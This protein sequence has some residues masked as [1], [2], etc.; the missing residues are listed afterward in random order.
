[1]VLA[2]RGDRQAF[3]RLFDRHQSSIVRFCA[4]FVGNQ[5]RGEELAQDVFIKLFR[6]AGRYRPEAKFTTFLFRVATNTCLNELRHQTHVADKADA[7]GDETRPEGRPEAAS[8]ESPD[9]HLEAKDVEKA[10]GLAL[11]GMSPRERAAFSMCRFEGLAYKDIGDALEASEAAVKSLIHRATLQVMERL[12][13]VRRGED[14][15]Q[16][17]HA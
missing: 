7:E 1:M 8:A 10:V 12:E 15:P 17:S 4:R 11:A 16:R 13:A 3:A 9:Q 14:L 6:S 2:A 5:A